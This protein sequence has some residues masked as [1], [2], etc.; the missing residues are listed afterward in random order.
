MKS[1]C[2]SLLL[3][4]LLPAKAFS[5]EPGSCRMDEPQCR[6]L[7]A[8]RTYVP[9][10][11]DELKTLKTS[12]PY[13]TDASV[14]AYDSYLTKFYTQASD[15]RDI[16]ISMYRWQ[17]NIATWEFVGVS[18]LTVFGIGLATYQLLAALRLGKSIK[19]SKLEM[20]STRLVATTS[21]VGVIILFLSFAFFVVFAGMIYPIT[22]AGDRG[23]ISSAP[24]IGR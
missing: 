6:E 13:Q 22:S 3:F 7:M 21:S 16:R 4:L 12:Q 2:A 17:Q 1:I 8:Y 19:D 5:Q 10:I 18:L 15:Y 24:S 23:A 11:V 14:R 20:S 9:A